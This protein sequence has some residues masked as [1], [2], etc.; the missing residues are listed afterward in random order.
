MRPLTVSQS[1][2]KQFQKSAKEK[3]T[4]ARGGK[5]KRNAFQI[6][7]GLVGRSCSGLEITDLVKNVNL[8]TLSDVV[9][10]EESKSEKI[11]VLLDVQRCSGGSFLKGEVSVNL[12][13]QCSR[14]GNLFSHP[15]HSHFEI[16]AN[17][18][19]NNIEESLDM[20][21]IPFPPSANYLD[22][23][24]V[25][26][27]AIEDGLPRL[28]VCGTSECALSTFILTEE[29]DLDFSDVKHIKNQFS[30]LEGLRNTL[31]EQEL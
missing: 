19:L 15:V 2:R 18:K 16:W 5:K 31:K 25:I 28:L 14:C 1:G 22:I 27:I 4:K 9:D 10:L 13:L 17:P 30:I 11:T 8:Q 12:R 23:T 21:E 7:R 29:T 24:E 26:G 3:K 6:R 20:N